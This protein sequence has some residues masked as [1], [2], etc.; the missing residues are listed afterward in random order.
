VKK[1]IIKLEEAG[2]L[3]KSPEENANMPKNLRKKCYVKKASLSKKDCYEKRIQFV[4]TYIA[5]CSRTQSSETTILTGRY[6]HVVY[7][8]RGVD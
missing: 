7:P 4:I 2:K 1:Q 3:I 6:I 8:P 5:I